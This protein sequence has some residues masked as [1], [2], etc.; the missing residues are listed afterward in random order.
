M[1]Y[2]RFHEEDG[3]AVAIT[4]GIS[5]TKLPKPNSS[6]K[7]DGLTEVIIGG[8]CRFGVEP[9]EIIASI[10]REGFYLAIRQPG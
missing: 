5:G 9:A 6:W 1:T 2:Y 10:E 3:S 8:R 7:A 4:D